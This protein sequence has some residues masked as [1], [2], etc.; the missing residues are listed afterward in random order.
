[1]DKANIGFCTFSCTDHSTLTSF[2]CY[3]GEHTY[4]NGFS[5]II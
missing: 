2:D 1:M 4:R 3:L 5:C